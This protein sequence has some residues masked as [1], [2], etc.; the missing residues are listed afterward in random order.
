VFENC[1][2]HFGTTSAAARPRIAWSSAR[3]GATI[4][5]NGTVGKGYVALNSAVGVD[6]NV[7]ATFGRDAGG[8]GFYDQVALINVAFSGAGTIG[9]G[10][11]NIATAPL[12]M[13]DASYVGWKSAGCTGLNI[14]A[15]TTARERPPPSPVSRRSTT[16]ATTSSIASSRLPR[17]RLGYEAVA[18]P[19]D[20]SSLAT[21]W[22]RA[23]RS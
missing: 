9:P 23:V 1:S 19:W 4:T 15:L 5:A 8:S 11:W 14:A 10:L 20:V 6:A 7:T 12:A 18:A 22:G 3:T 16:R 17:A 2:M 13:G 21:T